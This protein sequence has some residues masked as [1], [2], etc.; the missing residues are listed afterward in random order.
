MTTQTPVYLPEPGIVSVEQ[1]PQ[2][3]WPGFEHAIE[4][5]P[6]LSSQRETLRINRSTGGPKS[7]SEVLFHAVY[8]SGSD[9]SFDEDSQQLLEGR[10][11]AYKAIAIAT[12]L[13]ALLVLDARP[14]KSF[15]H[16]RIGDWERDSEGTQRTQFEEEMIAISALTELVDQDRADAID[17]L[18][19]ETYR[20]DIAGVNQHIDNDP[21][22]ALRLDKVGQDPAGNQFVTAVRL[23]GLAIKD[24]ND[25]QYAEFSSSG[26][27]LVIPVPILKN[28]FGALGSRPDDAVTVG[29]YAKEY[30]R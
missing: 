6:D 24:H 19:E 20:L 14:I 17:G 28:K 22:L 10:S 3:D 27:D 9:G 13:D 21:A 15:L 11:E 29:L 30:Q 7:E 2:L 16:H 8:E 1:M 25:P 26:A 5:D 18:L 12:R 23:A 4:V